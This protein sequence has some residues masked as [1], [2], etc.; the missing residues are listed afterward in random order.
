MTITDMIKKKPSSH[1]SSEL[2]RQSSFNDDTHKQNQ[3]F[4]QLHMSV[5]DL[6]H[7]H[8]PKDSPEI[9]TIEDEFPQGSDKRRPSIIKSS[10]M[11]RA[12]SKKSVT[13]ASVFDLKD[14]EQHYVV[15]IS[16]LYFIKN[17]IF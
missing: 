16:K 12:L 11:S 3:K 9:K 15:R 13:F 4:K 5:L 7:W 8:R 14:D 6:L 10:D 2:F 1:H 17:F